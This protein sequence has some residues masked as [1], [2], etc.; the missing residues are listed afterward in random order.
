MNIIIQPSEVNK[1]CYQRQKQESTAAHV[2]QFVVMCMFPVVCHCFSATYE[3]S[4][5][6]TKD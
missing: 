4:L 6:G 1:K 5:G 3:A 2:T